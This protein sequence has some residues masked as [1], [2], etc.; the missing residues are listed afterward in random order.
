MPLSYS[1]PDVAFQ[2]IIEGEQRPVYHVYHENRKDYGPLWY[3]FSIDLQD[4]Y[5]D[6]DIRELLNKELEIDIQRQEEQNSTL[7]TDVGPTNLNWLGDIHHMLQEAIDE[8]T[9]ILT[10][11]QNFLIRSNS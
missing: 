8:G 2:L 3:W 10:E 1:Q 4:T 6:F 9:V 5:N 11:C 7:G